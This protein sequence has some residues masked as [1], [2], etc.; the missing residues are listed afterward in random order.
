[1]AMPQVASACQYGVRL[2]IGEVHANGLLQ[3]T[4]HCQD[5]YCTDAIVPSSPRII[6]AGT[7]AAFAAA[8][9]WRRARRG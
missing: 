7:M 9:A 6:D 1:M 8:L 4:W 3:L 2:E 5:R